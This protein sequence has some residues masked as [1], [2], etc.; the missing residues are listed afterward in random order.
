MFTELLSLMSSLWNH[1]G[2]STIEFP[3]SSS[4]Q[5]LTGLFQN[6]CWYQTSGTGAES[7]QSQHLFWRHP[8]YSLAAVS[9]E[10]VR[11]YLDGNRT[12][13]PVYFPEWEFCVSQ[14]KMGRKK[15]F[16]HSDTK[17]SAFSEDAR[18]AEELSKSLGG[19]MGRLLG[20]SWVRS[21]SCISS[22]RL[23]GIPR[24]SAKLI[25]LGYAECILESKSLSLWCETLHPLLLLSTDIIKKAMLRST[26]ASSW[27]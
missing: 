18:F 22:F 14:K 16:Y 13:F 27:I 23:K 1:Q 24:T 25:C 11:F 7:S 6:A 5:A 17:K 4:K 9:S 10:L 19:A 8:G 21:L 2:G 20:N 3:I 12:L 26:F 15:V